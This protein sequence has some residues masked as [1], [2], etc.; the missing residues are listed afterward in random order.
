VRISHEKP[1]V[2]GYG[3]E[4]YGSTG[5]LASSADR[6]WSGLSAELRSHSDGIIAWKGMQRDTEICVDVRGNGS[7]VTREGDGIFDRIVAERGTVWL[8]PMGR[9]HSLVDFSDPAPGILHIYL[10]PSHFSPNS[11]GVDLEKLVISSIGSLRYESGYQDHQI[12]YAIVSELQAETSVGRL[13]VETLA[14]SKTMSVHHPL[15]F[16]LLLYREDLID[17]GCPACWNI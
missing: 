2:R 7:V 5:L 17:G 1:L 6:G 16:S 3:A 11:L 15:R 13:L 14:A 8:S 4:K 9:K 12:A 10:S